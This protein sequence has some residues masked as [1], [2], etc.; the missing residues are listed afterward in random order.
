MVAAD[1]KQPGRFDAE[2]T[3]EI[4]PACSELWDTFL[5]LCNSRR[6]GMSAQ[7]FTLIDVQAWCHLAGVVLSNWE[8]D[9]LLAMDA[10]ALKAL[11]QIR[12]AGATES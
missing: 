12:A 2:L 7:A 9:T 5:Q 4:P 8:L 1:R 3:V 6:A 11:N 10:A